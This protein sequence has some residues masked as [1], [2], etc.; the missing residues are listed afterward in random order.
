MRHTHSPMHLYFIHNT[1]IYYIGIRIYYTL[2][3]ELSYLLYYTSNSLVHKAW[4]LRPVKKTRICKSLTPASGNFARM[5]VRINIG[6]SV[7]T[8]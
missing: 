4:Y 8:I 7:W 3:I 5:K 2:T 6:T 1:Y